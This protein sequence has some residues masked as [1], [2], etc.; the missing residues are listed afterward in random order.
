MLVLEAATPTAGNSRKGSLDDGFEEEEMVM[1]P[2]SLADLKR[3]YCAFECSD[4][5]AGYED[6]DEASSDDNGGKPT[7]LFSV[8]MRLAAKKKRVTSKPP[9]GSRIKGRVED[10]VEKSVKKVLPKLNSSKLR[11]V[12]AVAK[13]I[14]LE[15]KWDSFDVEN[16]PTENAKRYRYNA[17]RS[18]WV[19][20]MCTVK[21]EKEPFNNGAMREC[22]RLKKLSNFSHNNQWHRDSNNY[23]AKRYMTPVDRE[24]YFND[25]KLQM[26]AKLW[27]EEYNRHHPPKKVDIFQMCV[28]EFV[29][30]EGSP[31]YHIEHFIQGKYIK[32]NS[33]SGFVDEAQRHTPQA[34]THFTFERSGHE[35]IIVDI[36]GVGDLYTDPQIHTA[37]D[38]VFRQ[39]ISFPGEGYGDGN[40]GTRGMALFFHTHICNPI[41]RSLKL[42]QFDL[43][44]SEKAGLTSLALKQKDSITRVRTNSIDACHSPTDFE[45]ANLVDFLRHRTN[46]LS[47]GVPLCRRKSSPTEEFRG[48]APVPG[49]FMGHSGRIRTS[50]SLSSFEQ[51]SISPPESPLGHTHMVEELIKMKAR[52]SDMHT[53]KSRNPDEISILGHVHLDL[54]KYHE[55][56]RFNDDPTSEEYDKEAALFHIKIAAELMV[57]EA[58]VTLSNLY[59]GLPH[60]LLTDITVEDT[61][62][63]QD[64]GLA[65]LE[66]AAARGDRHSMIALAQRLDTGLGLGTQEKNWAV[67]IN[68]YDRAIRMHTEEESGGCDGNYD[69]P[70]YLLMSRQAEMYREG[71]FELVKQPGRAGDLFSAAA[72]A[73]MAAGKGRL[74]NKWYMMAEEAWAEVEEEE[75]EATE[76][77]E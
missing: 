25:V 75:D 7:K 26:D 9:S 42:T 59:L 2:L 50:D 58:L 67:A 71:G 34:F 68:W 55:I 48:E 77:G 5:G 21:M 23:V 33:N 56:G 11:W 53:E 37:T 18:E 66:R 10:D 35:L 31:L 13:A 39:C 3:P 38:R 30:R 12:S 54:A 46:S 52:P 45:R 44:P 24:V 47:G 64:I 6:D 27:G 74:A 16:L 60:D 40:L 4:D 22:Y 14:S 19:E 1:D 36:Q 57:V 49:F 51:L 72:D 76:E 29:D 73:A 20:E 8:A 28:L 65:Y 32:Y 15:D 43:S 69:H 61:P 70:T 41:C 17:L 62:D 63:N